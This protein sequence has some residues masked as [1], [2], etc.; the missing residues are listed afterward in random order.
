MRFPRYA[1][2]V[3]TLVACTGR[4]RS[5]VEGTAVDD[6]V[7][8]AARPGV[9]AYPVDQFV[10]IKSDGPVAFHHAAQPYR[11]ALRLA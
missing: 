5:D 11:E 7:V 8:S 10:H 4:Q 1:L 9:A 2:A 3:V 6:A